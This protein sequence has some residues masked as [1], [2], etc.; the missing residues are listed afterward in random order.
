MNEKNWHNMP[1]EEVINELNTNENGLS[2]K[3]AKIRLLKNGKNELP[4][5]KTDPF[6]KIF[7]KQ[8]IEPMEILLI[9]AMI[10]SFLIG[11]IVDGFA[12]LF[13]IIVDVLMG[14]IQE[15]KAEKTAQSLENLIK[16]KTKVLRDTETEIESSELVLGDVV[17]LEPGNKISADMRIIECNNLQI[18]ESILT[19]ESLPIYKNTNIYETKTILAGRKNML[20]AGT[21][22]RKGRAKAIV[23]ETGSNTEVGKIAKEVSTRKETKSPLAIR[24]E[25]FTKQISILVIIVAIILTIIL[26]LKETNT[27]EILLSVIALSV[28]AM[29]EGLG[30]ALTMALTIASNRMSKKNV[31]VKKLNS[32]ESLGSC[33]IIASDKTGTLTVNEQTAKKILL[34]DNTS[35][36]IEGTGY[37][38]KG[39]IITNENAN[40]ENAYNIGK[41]GVLNNEATLEHHNKQIEVTGDS[42]D[43]AF[44]T[45][46]EKLKIEKSNSTIIS[47]IPYESEN[48]YSAVFYEEENKDYCTAKGSL[49]VILSFCKDTKIN[50]KSIPL[51]KEQIENQNEQ[52]AKQGYR[53]IALASKQITTKKEEYNEQDIKDLSFLGLVA[54]IDPVRV[55]VKDSIKECKTAGIKVLMITGDHPL[56]AFKIAEELD[57][58]NDYNE[59]TT[60]IEV[61]E[62]LAKGEQEFDKFI[63]T[64]KVFTRVTP[65]NKLQI[66]ESLKRQGEFVAVTGDGVNDAPAIKSANIGVAMGSGTDVA[67]ETASLII[68][69]DNFKS[70]V[71]GV[72]E[73]RNAYSNI[74]KVSYMLLSCGIAEVLFFILSIICN[75]PMPLIAVQLL[76]LNIVTDGLQDFA[77][78]FEKAEKDIMENKPRS[79]KETIF[80]KKLI[81]EVLLAG[82]TIGIIVFIVWVYLIKIKNMDITSARGH[83]MVLMVFMQN[84]HVLNC[85]SE[86][87][88]IFK[89]SLK[90]NKLIILSIISAI[91]LQIIVSEVPTF[92]KILQTSSIPLTNIF[93]LFMISSIIIIVMEIY[94]KE[95]KKHE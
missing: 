21:N 15:W 93:I 82:T 23:V 24:M 75:L 62:Y 27:S 51:N 59:V 25:K 3:E 32:A 81:E 52:L 65:L 19:G 68:L 89:I 40:I 50:N 29:P 67:K 86:K 28:S 91:V 49:E 1:I 72:K 11:E 45:L 73:G 88:S 46:G 42:I 26:L 7:V 43:I 47:K 16:V 38:P 8:I 85:R 10:V 66:V 39:K 70:I 87:H 17:L 48:K 94:K 9:I 30:L 60:G 20:Y 79:P 56:T 44:L 77:L 95:R 34:P 83:I 80:N 31:I 84:M 13:I 33:T 2:S 74:R 22:V 35:F 53:V 18:D 63:K 78:S 54:F 41:M 5:K 90:T 61:E 58:T 71:A 69:D 64:K 4:K 12:I 57:I 92:S 37:N 76:W 14:S 55:E 36:D 6:I